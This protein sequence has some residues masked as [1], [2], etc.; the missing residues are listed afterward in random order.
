MEEDFVQDQSQQESR[1]LRTQRKSIKVEGN[2]LLQKCTSTKSPALSI[3]ES[4]SDSNPILPSQL[5][6]LV[7]SLSSIQ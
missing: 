7:Q 2:P 1:K 6:D 5:S 3:F 4:L